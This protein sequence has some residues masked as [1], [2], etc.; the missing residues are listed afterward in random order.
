ML[1]R[2]V[3]AGSVIGEMGLLRGAPRSATAQAVD[4]VELLVL[5]RERF[6]QAA[7]EEPGFEAALYRMFLVQLAGRVE[8]LG[9][10]A[11]ALAR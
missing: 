11:S 7:R 5:T 2:R 4:D 8:Q 6:E 3:H 9:A 10:Q 1:L